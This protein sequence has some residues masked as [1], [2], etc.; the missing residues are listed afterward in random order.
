MAWTLFLWVTRLRNVAT[1]DEI[2]GADRVWTMIGASAFVLA[3]VVVGLRVVQREVTGQSLDRVDVVGI[4][5]FALVSIGWW[6]VR[7]T[8]IAL[9]DHSLGFIV[10]HI[11]LGGG[12]IAFALLALRGLRRG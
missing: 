10:I 4:S 5:S 6:L 8:Q 3:A 1:D 11:I 2:V 12:T 9:N 7:G